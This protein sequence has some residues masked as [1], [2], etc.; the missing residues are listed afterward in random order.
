MIYSCNFAKAIVSNFTNPNIRVSI[1]TF[2]DTADTLLPL[3]KD[4]KSIDT[5]LESVCNIIPKG[6]TFIGKGLNLVA[7]QMLNTGVISAVFA[8]TDGKDGGLPEA[9]KWSQQIKNLGGEIFGVGVGDN[10]DLGQLTQLASSPASTYVLQA[11]SQQNLPL[12][13][14]WMWVLL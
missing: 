4:L 1:I 14:G 10:I 11:A 5:S 7:N 12:V 3:S 2:A 9:L 8:V 13:G 6:N